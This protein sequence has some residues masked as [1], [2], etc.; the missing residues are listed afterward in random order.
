M[1]FSGKCSA[2]FFAAGTD[3]VREWPSFPVWL[4]SH[5]YGRV[6]RSSPRQSIFGRASL[7]GCIGCTFRNGP[8][9]RADQGGQSHSTPTRTRWC[10]KRARKRLRPARIAG[11]PIVVMGH[12]HDR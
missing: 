8:V 5:L 4:D 7:N 10:P 1:R 3:I 12:T 9:F 2:R 6:H 11:V